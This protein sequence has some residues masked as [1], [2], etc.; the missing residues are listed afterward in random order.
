MSICAELAINQFYSMLRAG[1]RGALLLCV[2]GWCAACGMAR[3][4][5]TLADHLRLACDFVNTPEYARRAAENAVVSAGSSALPL[6]LERAQNGTA[7]EKQVVWG[8][9][10]RVGGAAQEPLFLKALTDPAS[11]YFVCNS[12]RNALPD[13]YARFQAA[14]L[15]QRILSLLP[16]A[17]GAPVVAEEERQVVLLAALYGALRQA[18]GAKI[19]DPALEA[20]V[21]RCLNGSDEAVLQAACA[22]VLRY[23]ATPDGAGAL[24]AA[25]G[26]AK[27]PLA[28]VALCQ[29]VEA[30]RPAGAL[31]AIEKLAECGNP[32]VEV[33]A[34]GALAARG[35]DGV[36]E[37]LTA[38]TRDGPVEVRAEAVTLLGKYGGLPLIEELAPAVQDTEAEVRLAAVRALGRL[39]APAAAA[40]LRGMMG[41]QGDKDPQVRAEAALAFAKCGQ[42]GASGVLIKGASN[43]GAE[44]KK[45]RLEAI[46]ALGELKAGEGLRVLLEGLDDPDAEV[47]IAAADALGA[48]GDKRAGGALFRRMKAAQSEAS[49]LKS[50]DAGAGAAGGIAAA[51]GA[52]LTRLYGRIPESEPK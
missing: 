52:A 13:L 8:M 48:M 4:E 14:Q 12:L 3:A 16:G 6:I 11:D 32:V 40:L 25:A 46:W 17:G 29:A 7:S 5:D 1:W 2:A 34:L 47:A 18:Q 21:A 36:G 26:R 15:A 30:V 38:L 28:Q 22:T 24:L 44:A 43:R 37:A 39:A 45:Y 51:T 31:T 35:Y 33:V 23:A 50:P 27:S 42:V 19:L 10:A 41:P 49:G 9:L 20:A